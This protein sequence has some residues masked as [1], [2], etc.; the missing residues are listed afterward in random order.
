MDMNYF[1]PVDKQ[2]ADEIEPEWE[3]EVDREESHDDIQED[4]GE[5][6]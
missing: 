4:D 5:E 3:K 6:I 2:D 1:M